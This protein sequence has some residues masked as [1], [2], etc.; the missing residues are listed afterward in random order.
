MKKG[1]ILFNLKVFESSLPSS[2]GRE[3]KLSAIMALLEDDSAEIEFEANS[4]EDETF[5][6]YQTDEKLGEKLGKS[7]PVG[8]G[9]SDYSPTTSKIRRHTA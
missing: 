3:D 5:S 2:A 1:N 9:D 7:V 6:I 4:I 8:H